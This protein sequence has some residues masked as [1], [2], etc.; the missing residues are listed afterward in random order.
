MILILVIAD[1]CAMERLSKD[2]KDIVASLIHA[3]QWHNLKIISKKEKNVLHFKVISIKIG[4]IPVLSL[5]A[6]N[7]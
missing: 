5:I 4:Y 3:Y 6:M 1:S 7:C 2:N